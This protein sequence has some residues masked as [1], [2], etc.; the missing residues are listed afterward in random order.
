VFV[1]VVVIGACATGTH[2]ETVTPA[3]DVP[4]AFLVVD[5]NDLRPA[6]PGEGCRNPMADPRD[7]TRLELRSSANGMGD[8]VVPDGRYGVGPGSRLRLECASGSPVGI[9]TSN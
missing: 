8:Y 3:T 1:C 4:E 9:V 6:R 7:G 5:G 2:N